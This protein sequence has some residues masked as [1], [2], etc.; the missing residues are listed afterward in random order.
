MT[1][2]ALAT[3]LRSIAP[4]TE[5]HLTWTDDNTTATATGTVIDYDPDSAFR[6]I[7]T[8]TEQLLLTPTPTE[9]TVSELTPTTTRDRGTL[10]DVRY[11]DRPIETLRITDEGVEVPPYL[12]GYTGFLTAETAAGERTAVI[13]NELTQY[14]SRVIGLLG[15]PKTSYHDTLVTVR[16][17]S[18]PIRQYRTVDERTLTTTARDRYHDLERLLATVI[19]LTETVL[20]DHQLQACTRERA[21]DELTGL[22]NA[23][24]R[25]RTVLEP[26]RD[27]P[28]ADWKTYADALTQIERLTMVLQTTL[29]GDDT[30]P[31]E[32]K[33]EAKTHLQLETRLERLRV[34]L[35]D[36]TPN[37]GVM[38]D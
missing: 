7:E 19:R 29:E 8:A 4:E 22:Q 31:E 38:D 35:G 21:I 26:P 34:L 28:A 30:L 9:I 15:L 14:D 37:W 36:S 32:S 17:S 2:P 24:V 12:V 18:R 10:T 23:L 11:D 1:S 25:A 6:R 20:T 27:A 33:T 3:E 5:V 13:R 16:P